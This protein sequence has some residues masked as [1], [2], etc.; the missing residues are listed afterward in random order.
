M[1]RDVFGDRDRAPQTIGPFPLSEGQLNYAFYHESKADDLSVVGDFDDQGRLTGFEIRYRG[2]VA[3]DCR[4]DGHGP[5]E[6][7]VPAEGGQPVTL[8]YKFGSSFEKQYHCSAAR[9]RGEWLSKWEAER[10]KVEDMT[11]EEQAQRIAEW[12]QVFGA[13]PEV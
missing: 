4:I 12:N 3:G 8:V 13:D 5:D 7:V 6:I 1:S 2:P 10:P 11:P 9:S